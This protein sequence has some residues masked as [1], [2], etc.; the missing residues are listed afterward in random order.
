MNLQQII[1]K[2]E[3]GLYHDRPCG[4]PR[5]TKF[6]DD[7]EAIGLDYGPLFFAELL[8]QGAEAL[9]SHLRTLE[10]KP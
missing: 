7:M 6:Q 4:L 3:A 1:A 10:A 8:H 2:A 9:V 5:V